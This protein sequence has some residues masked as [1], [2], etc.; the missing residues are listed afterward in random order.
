MTCFEA[1]ALCETKHELAAATGEVAARLGFSHFSLALRL[2]GGTT[3]ED[4]PLWSIDNLPPDLRRAR[5]DC[6]IGLV[7][8]C[9]L[10]W[11][12]HGLP[13][14]WLVTAPVPE[15]LGGEACAE[16]FR[17]QARR[18]GVQ[19]GLCVPVPGA[20]GSA[21]SLTLATCRAVG[22][23]ALNALQPL[24]L[25]FSRHLHLACLPFIAAEH[26]PRAP[27]APRSAATL[28]SMS[29]LG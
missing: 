22:E 5:L 11:M 17:E 24:A 15:P 2:R 19:G 21:G 23:T 1:L 7:E 25:L 12:R 8:A 18:H 10:D 29:Y 16:R 27:R 6:F 9:G 14:P 3:P 20:D 4:P 28:R 26:A 13:H